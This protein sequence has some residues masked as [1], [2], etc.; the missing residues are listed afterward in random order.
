MRPRPA[1][2][3]STWKNIPPTALRGRLGMRRDT[4]RRPAGLSKRLPTPLFMSK[5]LPTPFCSPCQKDSRPLFVHDPFLFKKTPDPCLSAPLFVRRDPF[6]SAPP[7]LSTF[8]V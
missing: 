7:F 4:S 5:R 1:A 6:L 8:L 3:L 2:R